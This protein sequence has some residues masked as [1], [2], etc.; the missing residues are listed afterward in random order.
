MV[1]SVEGRG[2]CHARI[3][4]VRALA[5][6]PDLAYA[7][8]TRLQ[9]AV[10]ACIRLAAREKGLP[11]PEY[12]GRYEVDGSDRVELQA[13]CRTCNLILDRSKFVGQPSEPL[14]DRWRDAWGEVLEL[15][16]ELEARLSLI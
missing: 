1:K 11:E 4:Q 2:S 6:E 16:D 12:P 9:R 13:F 14:D 15:L 7:A 10:L 8:R 3:E 5:R